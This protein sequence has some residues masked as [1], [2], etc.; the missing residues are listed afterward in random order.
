MYYNANESSLL[1]QIYKEEF[2][3]FT[4]NV[5]IE[6]PAEDKSYEMVFNNTGRSIIPIQAGTNIFNELIEIENYSNVT[7]PEEEASILLEGAPSNLL[8]EGVTNRILTLKEKYTLIEAL[9][10]I[11]NF[12][13]KAG[14]NF[15]GAILRHPTKKP[16]LLNIFHPLTALQL[17]KSKKYNKQKFTVLLYFYTNRA[18]SDKVF[19]TA[20]A[21]VKKTKKMLNNL[22]RVIPQQKDKEKKLVTRSPG[23]YKILKIEEDTEGRSVRVEQGKQISVHE[24]ETHLREYYAISH[25]V[26]TRGILAPYYGTSVLSIMG[27]SPG[28]CTHITPFL[29]ANVSRSGGR[30]AKTITYNNVCTGS[31]SSKTFKGLSTL[32]HANLSSALNNKTVLPGALVYADACINITRELY[33]G[34]GYLSEFSPIP[35]M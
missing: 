14:R 34:V 20:K 24:I 8:L 29:S 15:Y 21:D 18:D 13:S 25:Q 9:P 2:K 27:A 35:E 19:N 32:D 11:E 16:I 6:E 31:E 4:K 3:Q 30:K 26:L 7:K 5:S 17:L 12:I 33:K 28:E 22:L 10:I 23:V 1:S